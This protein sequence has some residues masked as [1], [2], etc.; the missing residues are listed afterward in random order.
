MVGIRHFNPGLLKNIF[1]VIKAYTGFH[2]SKC[3]ELVII[4]SLL[5]NG[6][7]ILAPLLLCQV[8]QRLD[9]TVLCICSNIRSVQCKNIRKSS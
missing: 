7:Q 4:S 8:C 3:I 9:D 5:Q 6:F 1:I 2:D